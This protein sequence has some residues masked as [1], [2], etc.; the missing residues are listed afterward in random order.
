MPAV[1][2]ADRYEVGALIGRGGMGSVFAARDRLLDREVALKVADGPE[3]A[4]RLVRE[5]NVTARLDHPGI[6]AV[7]DAGEL[8]GGRRFYTMHLV[9]GE[10]LAS[11]MA[12]DQRPRELVRHLL[13]AAE[14]VAAA[15]AAGIVHRDLKPANVL[16][17]AHGETQVVDWGLA[18]PTA[19]ATARWPGLDV[20]R[21]GGTARYASPEQARGGPPDPRDDVYSLGVILRQLFEGQLP[22]EITAIC[23]RATS[24]DPVGRYA[25]AS[26]FANDLLRWFEGRRVSAHAYTPGELLRRSFEAYRLPLLVGLLGVIGVLSAV[27]AGW[28]KTS[29]SLDRAVLAEGRAHESRLR[30]LDALADL[31]LEEA[32]EATFAADRPRAEQLAAEVL[33]FRDDPTARG[34]L[35]AFARSPRATL[36]QSDPAPACAWSVMGEGG[37]WLACGTEQSVTRWDGGVLRWSVTAPTTLGELAGGE[38]RAAMWDGS[39]LVLDP[40]SGTLRER[41]DAPGTGVGPLLGVREPWSPGAPFVGVASSRCGG[42]PRAA[43]VIPSGRHA[44]ACA[45][46]RLLLGAAD[47]FT[48][49]VVDTALTGDHEVAAL[50]THEA[51]VV[52]GSIRGALRAYAWDGTLI[53]TGTSHAGSVSQLA[54][55]DDGGRVAVASAAG[56]VAIWDLASQA[57]VV[58]IPGER[59]LSLA[60]D[61]ET[62]LVHDRQALARWQVPAGRPAV[63]RG[64]VGLSDVATDPARS[65]LV[66]VGGE[67]HVVD[68]HGDNSIRWSRAGEGLLKAVALHPATGAPVFASMVTPWLRGE[69]GA[70]ATSPLRRLAHLPDGTLLALGVAQGLWRQAGDGFSLLAHGTFVDLESDESRAVAVAADGSIW[71]IAGAA[72]AIDS[73]PG[74]RAASVHGATIAV[75]TENRVEILGD[76]RPLEA[77]DAQLTDLAISPDGTR[78]AAGTVD[79]RVLVWSLGG[80]VL[81]GVLPGHAERVS[82]IDFL[83]SGDLV[84]ASWD[85]SVRLWALDV[86]DGPAAR[87]ARDI[88]GA[89]SP[90]AAK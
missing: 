70:E 49:R 9:R 27:A 50:M 21:G 23:T 34:V 25:D 41:I 51:V 83:P 46:G 58:Q 39:T 4:A 32:V 26:E 85:K 65:R 86:L 60:F 6:V 48:S 31:R 29:R 5:A 59:V 11:A 75:A 52:L 72:A 37:G 36:Q 33:A 55:S 79:G 53:A 24:S 22:P 7:F 45:D 76:P 43:R 28:W 67:G 38:L 12:G 1:R 2:P 35:A 54:I 13:Q 77:G 81:L 17:G 84:S 20:V 40:G 64:P 3:G 42:H 78:I 18:S 14:A 68:V 56:G 63:L 15:H 87:L 47:T 88:E 30:A 8:P 44:V 69:A 80:H 90:P 61:G 62:L 57:A 19:V 10:T 71:S 82:G 89:W 66:A 74:A 73:H 16:I